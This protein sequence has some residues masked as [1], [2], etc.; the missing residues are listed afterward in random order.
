MKKRH[1]NLGRLPDSRVGRRVSFGPPG[2]VKKR[3]G[4]GTSGTIEGEVWALDSRRG[5]WGQYCYFSQLIK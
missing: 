4:A 3:G 5:T 1:V 2:D